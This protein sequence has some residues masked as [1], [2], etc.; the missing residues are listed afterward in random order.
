MTTTIGKRRGL[1]VKPK[2]VR[3]KRK[4]SI[5]RWLKETLGQWQPKSKDAPTA[6]LKLPA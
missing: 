5:R 2:D 3:R 1:S 6:N 4:Q